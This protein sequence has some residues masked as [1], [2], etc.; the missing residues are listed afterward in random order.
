MI[1]QNY[2]KTNNKKHLR[3]IRKKK[4]K[5][6]KILI[7]YDMYFLYYENYIQRK[8]KQQTNKQNK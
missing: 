6:K 7:V 4:I 3:S 1:D 8:K 2:T 5:V